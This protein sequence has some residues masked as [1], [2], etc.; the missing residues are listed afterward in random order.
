[1][2]ALLDELEIRNAAIVGCSLGGRVALELAVA[3]PDLVR[4]LVLVGAATPEAL[5]AAPEM[6]E[7]ATELKDAIGRHDLD[8]AVEVNLRY[9]V[10]G[11]HRTPAQVD[12]ALRARIATTQRDAFLNTK[13]L[14]ARW[15]EEPLV[16]DLSEKLTRITAPALVLAGE[17]DIGFIHDQACLFARHIVGAHLQTLGHTAHAASAERPAGF[18]ELVVPFLVTTCGCTHSRDRPANPVGPH[19]AHRHPRRSTASE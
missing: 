19:P 8:A 16:T 6:A 14:A 9:W 15:R 10:D 5:A 18:D 13:G 2:V 12:P 1:V 11:P 4:A 3:R 7:Y 17:L